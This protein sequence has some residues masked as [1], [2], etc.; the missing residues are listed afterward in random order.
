MANTYHQVYIQT[1]FAPKYRKAVLVEK[2]RPEIFSVI[3]TLIKDCDCKPYIVNGVSDHVHC[4]F[5]LKPKISISDLMQVVKAK[6]SKHINEQG[7]THRRFEWQVGYGAFSYSRKQRDE[8]YKYILRQ[9]EHHRHHTFRE[10][11]I[12]LLDEFEVPY[13][14]RYLFEDLQ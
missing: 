9:E 14:D 8:V 11:Y 12:G 13:E 2:H 6:S 7:L 10:E 4:F 1:V 5:G 3:A